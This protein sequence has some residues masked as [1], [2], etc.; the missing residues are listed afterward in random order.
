[1]GGERRLAIGRA[2]RRRQLGERVVGQILAAIG[3][4]SGL[5]EGTQ[6]QPPAVFDQ[7][8]EDGLAALARHLEE[9]GARA[10]ARSIEQPVARGEVEQLLTRLL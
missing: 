3:L 8:V 1:M 10:L 6:A 5:G 9:V 2:G 4:E 7:A